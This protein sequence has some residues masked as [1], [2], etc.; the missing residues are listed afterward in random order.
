MVSVIIPVYNRQNTLERLFASLRLV[1]FRPV[2]FIFVDNNST[3]SS[4]SLCEAFCKELM[5]EVDDVETLRAVT[6]D[7]L[8]P[9]ACAARN[10][11]LSKARG[12]FCCFFDSDDEFAADFITSMVNSIGDA[13]VCLTRTRMIMPDGRER[14]RE[15]WPNPTISEHLLAQNVSTQ[16]FIARTSYVR[17]IGG[18]ADLPIW[19][20]Y[21][22]GVRLLSGQYRLVREGC[23]LDARPPRL[24]W[25]PGIWHRIY[26]HPDSITGGSFGDRAERISLAFDIIRNE[27][28][29]LCDKRSTLALEYRV[30]IVRGHM[31][32]EGKSVEA[33]LLPLNNHLLSCRI[34]EKYVAC[35]GRG[36]WRFALL[37][38]KLHRL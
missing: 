35:H 4:R 14:I 1:T 33:R 34:L 24:A 32:A 37:L 22:F 25:N 26:Q 28:L 3:D 2:E 11:G 31:R 21:E 36:A 30:A 7:C 27:T 20:D 18:W 17:A 23:V 12:E 16:S 29:S 8:A 5:A 19:Q 9:G 6:V 10:V 38:L 13:D 15:G